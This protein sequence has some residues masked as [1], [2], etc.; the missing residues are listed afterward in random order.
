MAKQRF[1]EYIA[2][3]GGVALI[4]VLLTAPAEAADMRPGAI[5]AGGGVGLMG[6]T[7]DGTAFTL[8][9][10]A[11]QFINSNVSVGPLAQLAFTGDMFLLGLSG[12][13]KYWTEIPD[14]ARRVKLNFQGGLGFVHA[15]V[16]AS[17]TSWLIPL[18]VGL[19]YATSP[20]TT[21]TADL[22]LNFTYL[23]NTPRHDAHVMPTFT[24][25]FRF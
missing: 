7:P 16:L 10:R 21:L 11:E 12:Q 24:V 15:N 22:L 2:R 5:T 1:H 4:L 9:G 8:S 3:L 14:T 20:Q 19:D 23:E 18:G 17:D 25:G 6:G 13:I